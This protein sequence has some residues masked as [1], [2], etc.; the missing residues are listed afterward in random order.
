MAE[1]HRGRYG[2]AEQTTAVLHDRLVLGHQSCS[3]TSYN[4]QIPVRISLKQRVERR[5][6]HR[7]DHKAW[8]GV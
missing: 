5:G 1:A 7:L 4:E 2:G 8:E 3:R 6:S